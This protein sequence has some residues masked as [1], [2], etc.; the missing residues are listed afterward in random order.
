MYELTAGH[1]VK[2]ESNSLRVRYVYIFSPTFYLFF[3]R[4]FE[5]KIGRELKLVGDGY[6]YSAW[7]SQVKLLPLFA[8]GEIKNFEIC[9][10]DK[11]CRKSFVKH[12]AKGFR[13]I[14]DSVRFSA[15]KWDAGLKIG[16]HVL[17]SVT[18]LGAKFDDCSLSRSVFTGSFCETPL[19]VSNG[20]CWSVL[21]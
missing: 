7:D 3:K 5:I 1:L 8:L 2:I 14:R 17:L 20:G 18:A 11:S 15:P 6:Y 10:F 12:F 16:T 13:S 19:R 4:I 21:H 9:N